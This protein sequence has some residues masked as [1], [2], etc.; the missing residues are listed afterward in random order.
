MSAQGDL[1]D[2]VAAMEARDDA[3]RQVSDHA[4]PEWFYHALHVVWCLAIQLEEFT[5]DDVWDHIGHAASTHEPRALGAVMKRAS[6]LGY[7]KATDRYRPSARA[8]CH[9]RPVRIW[10]SL[11]RPGAA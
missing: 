6:S 10:A 2:L 1:L 9:A 11:I 7:V 3:L 5:T 4:D 8:A